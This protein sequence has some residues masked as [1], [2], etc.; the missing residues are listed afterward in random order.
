MTMPEGLIAFGTSPAALAAAIVATSFVVEDAAIVAAALLASGGVLEP[1]LALAAIFSGILLGDLGLYGLGAAA[2]TQGWARRRIG[3]ARIERGR[4]WLHGRLI[5]ALI[6]ARFVPGL[7][8]PTFGASGFLGVPFWSF[9]SIAVGATLAWTVLVFGVVYAF[10]AMALDLVG[11]W[12]WAVG[13][14]ILGFA[15]IGPSLLKL[16]RRTGG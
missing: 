2:R 6:G 3:E 8:L 14:A 15:L 12:K 16:M 11:P 5:P 10:G 4:L 9:A 13:A 7:R 1:G